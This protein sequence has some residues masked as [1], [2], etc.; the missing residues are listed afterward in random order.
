M[1]FQDTAWELEKIGYFFFKFQSISILAIH[2]HRRQKLDHYV[3]AS[4]D[5]KTTRS[6]ITLLHEI[7]ATL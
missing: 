7:L 4:T 3:W 5:T 2:N 1:F 6:S